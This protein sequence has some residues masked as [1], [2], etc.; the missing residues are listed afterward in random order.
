MAREKEVI[1]E[2]DFWHEKKEE[3]GWKRSNGA[4]VK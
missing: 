4:S 1:D 3:V 2:I